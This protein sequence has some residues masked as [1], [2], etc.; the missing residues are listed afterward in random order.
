MS[1]RLYSLLNPF[2]SVMRGL[3]VP[4]FAL[5]YLKKFH[6]PIQLH[7]PTLYYD[8][9]F[10]LATHTDTTLW[11]RLADK[12][13]V[14]DFVASHCGNEILNELYGVYDTST[15]IRWD[16]L[17]DEFVL[18]T[19]HGCAS[20][21]FVRDKA[22][23]NVK[24]ISNMLDKLLSLRYGDLTAQPH[25]SKIKPR[26]IAEKL[27]V[28]DGDPNRALIDYKFNCFNGF[29]HSCA[30]FSDRLP[31]THQFGRMIYD[32]EWQP[33]P[34]WIENDKSV[35]LK[36]VDRPPCLH[37]MIQ[38]A[39]KLSVGFPYVRVDLYCIDARPVFG[40][41]TFTPGLA[42]YTVEFQ[43]ALGDLIVLPV[44]SER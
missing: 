9:V 10:W 7:K 37:E 44:S 42:P 6:R 28:Q 17:P 14:R 24:E 26:I 34:E 41:M 5:R 1:H 39:S 19:T 11:S 16:E 22:R 29:V 36:D 3:T 35:R 8:K 31:N 18:K 38:I 27:M 13:E 33:H 20:N 12:Y 32:N 43:K 21:I 2:S 30:V 23:A 40:E 15:D 25:Y 4:I